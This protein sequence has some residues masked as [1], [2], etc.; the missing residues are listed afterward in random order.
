MPEVPPRDEPGNFPSNTASGSS[1]FSC[2]MLLSDL[3][4]CAFEALSALWRAFLSSFFFLSVYA[5]SF[6][7]TICLE[8]W[9]A[10][11]RTDTFGVQFAGS[12]AVL[13]TPD[14]PPGGGGGMGSAAVLFGETP[15]FT[16]GCL[17]A[18][19][20][21]RWIGQQARLANS[22][23]NNYTYRSHCIRA[24]GSKTTCI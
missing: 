19:L 8:N 5:S 11:A 15:P 23:M 22:R 10:V 13:H 7:M 12:I 9:S 18:L 4:D 21:I 2:I 6:C 17:L 20:A 1:V 16:T 3:A 24:S 14:H